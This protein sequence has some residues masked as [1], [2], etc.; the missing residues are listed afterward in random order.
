MLM[1]AVRRLVSAVP[2]LL[3]ISLLVFLLLDLMPGDAAATLAG[4]NASAEQI[5]ELRGRLG[6]DQPVLLRYWDW[7]TSA[8]H[9]DL[10]QSLFSSQSVTDTVLERLPVTASLGLAALLLVVVIG[11]PLGIFAA[12][13]PGS[14]VDR[15]LSAFA[16]LAMALPPFVVGLV[17]V[18]LFAVN[19]GALPATGYVPLSEG[20]LGGWLRNLVLPAIAVAAI[21]V[22]ELARQTRG[23]LVDAQSKDYIRTVRAKGVHERSVLLKHALKNAGVPIAT[24]LGLQV[25]RLLAGS[26]TVEFVFAMPGFGALAVNAVIQRDL[27][28]ILGVVLTSAL[29]VVV[30]NILTDLS[31]GFFNP[32]LRA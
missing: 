18:L 28:M 5:A 3:A 19:L 30:V 32:R 4:E 9:G 6:L 21:P 2:L 22:A 20:G 12:R 29:I 8:V 24:V 13:R 10:G 1:L 16:S 14:A 17:L 25:N 15:L 7:L 31:Y 27:P 26:V 23:A 11:L